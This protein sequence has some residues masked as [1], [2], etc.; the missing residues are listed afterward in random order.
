MNEIKQN[1]GKIV[2]LGALLWLFVIYAEAGLLDVPG[3][4]LSEY[5]TYAAVIIGVILLF[6]LKATSRG[7][8]LAKS[9]SL[10]RLEDGTFER[11]LRAKLKAQ[12]VTT[13]DIIE[14]AV[15][16]AKKELRE[17]LEKR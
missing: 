3:L 10:K 17:K 1:I 7:E 14:K 5:A 13:P 12:G 16:E 2:V 4:S 11:E 8:A 15:A 6:V 9:V